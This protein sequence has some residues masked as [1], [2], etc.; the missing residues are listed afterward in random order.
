MSPNVTK[1]FLAFADVAAHLASCSE[2]DL[3]EFYRE[4]LTRM[5]DMAPNVAPGDMP[6]YTLMEVLASGLEAIN[7]MTAIGRRNDSSQV[8]DEAIDR[9]HNAAP[10]LQTLL[11]LYRDTMLPLLHSK[12]DPITRTHLMAEAIA[13]KRSNSE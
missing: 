10:K 11:T 1:L 4:L 3:H 7:L 6:A 8:M 13:F 9:V 12:T 2:D 5:H